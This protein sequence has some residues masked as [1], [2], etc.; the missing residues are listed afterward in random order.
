MVLQRGNFTV[1][2]AQ[3]SNGAKNHH[4]GNMNGVNTMRDHSRFAR[5]IQTGQYNAKAL[6]TATYPLDRT[7]EAVQAVGER[8]TVGAV[9]VFG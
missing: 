2:A 9:V 6:V 5:L 8:T 4:P 1:P 7:K 3:W